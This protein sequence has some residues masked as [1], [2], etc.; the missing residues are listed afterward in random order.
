MFSSS[1]SHFQP[2]ARKW[3]F[4]N[5]RKRNRNFINFWERLAIVARRSEARPDRTWGASKSLSRMI[6]STSCFHSVTSSHSGNSSKTEAKC[7]KTEAKISGRDMCRPFVGQVLAAIILKPWWTSMNSRWT[8]GEERVKSLAGLGQVVWE[9]RGVCYRLER[10]FGPP[11]MP[12]KLK[13]R[14][15]K[16]SNCLKLWS[17]IIISAILDWCRS[18]KL[19]KL[20]VETGLKAFP[21]C[22]N[23]KP[24]PSRS[25]AGASAG[26]GQAKAVQPRS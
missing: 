9:V 8:L 17:I 13:K 5:S 12:K 3:N 24:T 7:S 18:E 15:P 10:R 21:A 14:R 19:K 6:V 4:R 26:P 11:V 25:Q 20:W 2:D 22:K 23:R 1:S 16:S